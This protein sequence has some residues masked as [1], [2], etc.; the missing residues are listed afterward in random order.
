MLLPR[1]ERTFL[2]QPGPA[3]LN[4]VGQAVLAVLAVLEVPAVP[5][6]PEVLAVLAILGRLHSITSA[7]ETITVARPPVP[8][9]ILAHTGM[10]SLSSY[11]T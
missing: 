8:R 6:V 4:P 1:A 7:A 3:L 11:S 2:P 10:V 9:D 5:A